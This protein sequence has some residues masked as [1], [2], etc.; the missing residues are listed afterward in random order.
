MAVPTDWVPGTRRTIRRPRCPEP[1]SSLAGSSPHGLDGRPFFPASAPAPPPGD[2]FRGDAEGIVFLEVRNTLE[3]EV[4]IR[5]RSQAG[6]MD[7]GSAPA[8]TVTRLTFPWGDFGRLSLQLEP[9]TGS[10][11]TLPPL[12]VHAG[13]VLELVIQSPVDRSTLRR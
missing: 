5:V 11:F 13:A 1:P 4:R 2:P 6:G 8:R 9:A 7:L 12:E 10:R 3:E